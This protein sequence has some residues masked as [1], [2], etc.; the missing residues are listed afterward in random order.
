MAT[1]RLGRSL[2]VNTIIHYL[3]LRLPSSFRVATICAADYHVKHR[4]KLYYPIKSRI[5]AKLW[6]TAIPINAEYIL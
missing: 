4:A 6:I 5:K 3:H 1:I 2:S